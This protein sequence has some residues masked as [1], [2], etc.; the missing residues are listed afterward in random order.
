MTFNIAAVSDSERNLSIHFAVATVRNSAFSRQASPRCDQQVIQHAVDARNALRDAA[1]IG[2]V[3]IGLENALQAD[4]I[5]DA[6][7]DKR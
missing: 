7:H 1:D 5:G 3:C 4:S 6:P 2:R